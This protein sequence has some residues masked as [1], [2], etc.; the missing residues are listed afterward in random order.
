MFS[1]FFVAIRNGE[2]VKSMLDMGFQ[3][4]DMI[5]AANEYTK[6]EGSKTI[7][8]IHFILSRHNNPLTSNKENYILY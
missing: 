4:K 6:H 3:M 2:I 8:N 7:Q 1:L 5:Y